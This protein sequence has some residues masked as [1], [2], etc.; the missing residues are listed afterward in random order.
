MDKDLIKD[1]IK[2]RNKFCCITQDFSAIIIHKW[3]QRLLYTICIL[4]SGYSSWHR[5]LAH[6]THCCTLFKFC[7]AL[8]AEHKNPLLNQYR[9]YNRA[10]PEKVLL[11]TSLWLYSIF[12]NI[13]AF[14]QKKVNSWKDKIV[15]N[16][17]KNF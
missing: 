4:K 8:F 11:C 9:R 3:F 12:Y 7:S 14:Y 16:I 13:I 15:K 10:I 6:R 2:K 1:E 17:Q 5:S